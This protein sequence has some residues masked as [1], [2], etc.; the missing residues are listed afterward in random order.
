MTGIAVYCIVVGVLLIVMG[1]HSSAE[2]DE[3]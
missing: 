3:L 1:L 2:K